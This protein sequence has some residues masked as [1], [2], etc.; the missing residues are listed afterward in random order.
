MFRQPELK[1]LGHKFTAEDV[2]ADPDKVTAILGIPEPTN[3]VYLRQ[4]MG[5]VYYS[6]TVSAR[7]T[8]C[9]TSIEWPTR[10][11]LYKNQ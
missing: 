2:D 9:H 6:R 11:F 7:T 8:Q 3:V 10:F 5:M 4:F 1:F